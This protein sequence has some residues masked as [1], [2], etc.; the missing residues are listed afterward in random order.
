MHCA[1]GNSANHAMVR[2]HLSMMCHDASVRCKDGKA[3]RCD[4]DL[5][6]EGLLHSPAVSA[7]KGP[8]GVS[9]RSGRAVRSLSGHSALSSWLVTTITGLV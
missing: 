5:T 3:K 6:S 4:N 9:C 1:G 2:Q 7:A 8:V